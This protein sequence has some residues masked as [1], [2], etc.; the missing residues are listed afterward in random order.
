L[1][2]KKLFIFD[3][4]GTLVDAYRAIEESLN[5]TLKRLGYPLVTFEE[6]KRNVGKGDRLFMAAFFRSED[7]DK[8]LRIYR[9]HHKSSLKTHA[10]LRPYAVWLLSRLK[11]NNRTIAIASN[12]PVFF[13]D[14]ILKA[15]GIKKY[16]DYVL[17]ADQ[18]KSLK[19]N[20]KILNMIMDRFRVK[21]ED[22]VFIGDMDIDLETAQ[23]ARVDAIF[24][25]G[26]S[27]KTSDIKKYKNKKIAASLKKIKL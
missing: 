17:C 25:K 2:N 15:V 16:L 26:G 9:L 12:R 18:I 1:N 22:T 4:D 19:P 7:I 6:A 21:R 24:V 14:I 23:R 5:F 8:A 20:P 10:K 11:R 13:T 3:L 27:T